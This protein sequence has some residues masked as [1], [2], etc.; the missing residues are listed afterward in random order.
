MTKR[1]KRRSR[2]PKRGVK[3]FTQMAAVAAPAGVSEIRRLSYNQAVTTNGAGFVGL[4]VGP[5]LLVASATEWANYAARWQEYRVLATKVTMTNE[6][7]QT[8]DFVIFAT[9]RGGLASTP[10]S[11]TALWAT[12]GAKVFNGVLTQKEPITYEAKA[13]D[14]E[15]QLYTPVAN[16]AVTYQVLMGTIGPPTTATFQVFVEWMVQFKG[17]K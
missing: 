1:N 14:L 16:T 11:V 12:S 8:S 17:T 10:V 13:I 2:G 15:D 5:G 3:S 9:D 4:L 6:G 7:A